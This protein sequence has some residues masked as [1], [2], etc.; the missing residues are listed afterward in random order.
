[1]ISSK[2]K[3]RQERGQTTGIEDKERKVKKEGRAR[4]I[5]V[6]SQGTAPSGITYQTPRGRSSRETADRRGSAASFFE[7]AASAIGQTTPTSG[8]FQRI[9]PSSWGS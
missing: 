4:P 5:R 9:P 3:E 2:N 8:S 1:M 7:R 6:E